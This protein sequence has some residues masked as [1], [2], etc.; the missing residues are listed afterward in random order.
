MEAQWP[1]IYGMNL[2]KSQDITKNKLKKKT[3]NQSSK[4]NLWDIA[5]AVERGKVIAMQSSENKKNLK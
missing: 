2:H 4:Q 1:K 3:E 5:R